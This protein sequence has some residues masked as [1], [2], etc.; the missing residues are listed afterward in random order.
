MV[1]YLRCSRSY[2][3]SRRKARRRSRG[4]DGILWLPIGDS[5]YARNDLGQ[6]LWRA[7]HAG[8]LLVPSLVDL[9]YTREADFYTSYPTTSSSCPS[10]S[11][12]GIITNARS[13]KR[14]SRGFSSWPTWPMRRDCLT[15]LAV[16]AARSSS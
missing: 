14:Q 4:T 9:R 12:E 3:A 13:R 7:A 11:F 1:Y 6:N 16:L 2:W 10:C 5:G 8:A 15:I